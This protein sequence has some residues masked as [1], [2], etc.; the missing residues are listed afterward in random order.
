ML[1]RLWAAFL[2]EDPALARKSLLLLIGVLIGIGPA[3]G[4]RADSLR[5][6]QSGICHASFYG[7]ESGLITAS[8]EPFEPEALTAAH[9][10]LRFGARLLVAARG[11]SVI[12]RINDRGPAARTGRCLDLSKGA[13]RALGIVRAGVAIVRIKRL[14]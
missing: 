4:A 11:R 7:Y 5:S 1:S 2:L 10:R 12:V 13:A 9:R 8:G 6:S 3:I 14:N